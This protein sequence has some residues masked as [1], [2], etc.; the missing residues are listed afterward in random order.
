MAET[1]TNLPSITFGIKRDLPYLDSGWQRFSGHYLIY[2]S[3]GTFTLE[4]EDARWLLPP[5]RA[6]WVRA[7]ELIRI[8][9]PSPIISSSV[10]Y[11]PDVLLSLSFNCRVFGVT[12]LAR[13]MILYA[14]QW[15]MHRDPQNQIADQFFL[16]LANICLELASNAAQFWLPHGRSPEL[17][18]AMD[19][20]LQNLQNTLQVDGIAQRVNLSKRTLA[21]RFVEEANITCGQFI[22]HARMMRAIELLAEQ[23]TSVIEVA[24]AVGFQSISAF[25]S[26]FRNFTQETPSQYRRQ[27]VPR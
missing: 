27:F 4:T 11:A 16:T 21:R 5:Q 6:A 22:H 13:E 23:N 2:A 25:N 12:P 18:I 20:I 1:S 17:S 14:M 8:Y 3:I 10:L 7:G 19:Y 24:Y 26:A 15:D 9:A